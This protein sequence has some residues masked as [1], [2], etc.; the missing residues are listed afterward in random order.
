MCSSLGVKLSLESRLWEVRFWKVSH[1]DYFPCRFRV[2]AFFCMQELAFNLIAVPFVVLWYDRSMAVW[3]AIGFL[4]HFVL[5]AVIIVGPW[6]LPRCLVQREESCAPKSP[7][8]L[9]IAGGAR[10]AKWPD[11][12]PGEDQAVAGLR[13]DQSVAVL[14]E[15]EAAAAAQASTESHQVVVPERP[16]FAKPETRRRGKHGTSA[17]MAIEGAGL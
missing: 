6:V 12:F 5:A 2:V 15:D 9:V 3:Q 1:D 11:V 4:P 16:A 17:G 14:R 13:E 8:A 7:A 10:A